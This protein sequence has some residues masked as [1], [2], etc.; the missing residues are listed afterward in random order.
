MTKIWVKGYWKIYIDKNGQKKRKWIK[1][2]Y[3]T[4]NKTYFPK[5]K[6]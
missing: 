1:G 4:V 6:F 3:K 2:H 5:F